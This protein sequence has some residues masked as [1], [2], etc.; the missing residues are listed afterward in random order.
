MKKPTT[1]AYG[2]D[3]TWRP[4]RSSG[5]L[6]QCARI[7]PAV[8]AL[9]SGCVDGA[10]LGACHAA[11]PVDAGPHV[12]DPAEVL[13]CNG[14]AALCDRRYDQV[15][16]PTAHNAMSNSDEG[17]YVPN[18]RHPIGR[19][20]RDGIRALMLDTHYYRG[21][22]YLCHDDCRLGRR[23]LADAL[24]SVRAFLDGHPDEVVTLLLE[25][26]I[27]AED[28]AA[29]VTTSGLDGYVH[30]HVAGTPWPSLRE[31]I[32]SDRRLVVFTETGGGSPPWYL[33]LYDNSWETGF[34]FATPTDLSCAGN[35]GEARNPLFVLNHFMG[36]PI[37]RMGLAEEINHDPM[38]LDRARRCM[39]ESRH[40]PNF[41][42]VD[43]YDV[44]DLFAVVDALNREPIP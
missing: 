20:L 13:A 24:C 18:Q 42:A 32:A 5:W 31:M 16:Y 6:L 39:R 37:A 11:R 41:V 35:R 10:D 3:T 26:H 25:S 23:P 19:A 40:L 30:A 7:G 38:L 22:A 29:A 43:F 1:N 28:T 12:R 17:W 21:E 9:V 36:D 8:L 33:S 15:V 27:S 34:S 2:P 44:G 4:G 14:A